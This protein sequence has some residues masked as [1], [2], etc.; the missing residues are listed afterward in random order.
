MRKFMTAAILTMMT[1]MLGGCGF[2]Y[3]SLPTQTPAPIP[4]SSAQELPELVGDWHITL[5]Q[6]GGIMGISRTIEI[7]SSGKLTIIDARTSKQTVIQLPA[8]RIAALA[9]LVKASRYQSPSRPSACADCFIY[10]LAIVSGGQS[11]QVQLDDISIPDSGLD[12]LMAFILEYLE[13]NN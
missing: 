6:S 1:W 11:F 7:S 8:D 3:S 4:T 5:S 2:Y 10:N 9:R 13:T 12:S